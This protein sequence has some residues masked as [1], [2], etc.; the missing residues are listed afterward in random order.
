MIFPLMQ[1]VASN[2]I[3]SDDFNANLVPSSAHHLL[4]VYRDNMGNWFS[5]LR[6]RKPPWSVLHL[7]IA[8][9]TV[10]ELSIWGKASHARIAIFRALL[11]VSAFTLDDTTSTYWREIGIANRFVA[12][13]EMKQCLMK[14]LS[15]PSKAKYKDTLLALLSLVSISV[16]F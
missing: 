10:S 6:T 16:G 15:G 2:S 8:L 5:P 13:L 12:Q 3:T 7:P 9:S 1:S 14:E 4:R 11:A